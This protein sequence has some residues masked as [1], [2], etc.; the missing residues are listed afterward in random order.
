MGK[1]YG[2]LH[3]KLIC[4]LIIT[5]IFYAGKLKAQCTVCGATTFTVNLTSQVDTAWTQSGPVRNGTCCAG[6][7]CIKFVVFVNPGSDLLSFDVTNPSPSGSA[8]YQINCGGTVSIGTP[9]C[10][11]NQTMVCITYCKPGGDSPIYHITATKTVK[12]S[13]DFTVRA[14]CAATMTVGGLS[15]ASITWTSISPGAVGAYNSYLSCAAACATTTVTPTA[16]TPTLISYLV[17]GSPLTGCPGTNKDTINVYVVPAMTVN[18]TPTNPVVC[19]GG[20]ATTAITATA[21]G[22]SP[23]LTYTWNT[24]ATTQSIGAGVGNY[25]VLVGDATAGCPPISKTITV[26]AVTTPTAPSITSNGPLCA[27]QTLSLNAVSNGATYSW[28]GPNSF[29]SAVQSPTVG[30]VTTAA[31]GVYSAVATTSGCV[32]TTGTLS[33]TINNAPSTPTLG[34]NSPVCSGQNLIFTSN[35]VSSGVYSW[36]GP[37]GFT[38]SVQNPT[39]TGVS[40]L[41]TGT[42]TLFITAA[43]CSSPIGTISVVVNSTPSAPVPNSNAPI[44]AGQNLGFT[45]L[46]GGGTFSWT[47]P[48]GFTSALQNPTITGASS[49]ATGGYSVTTTVAGCTSPAGVINVTVNAIPGIPSP[50]SNSPLCSGQNLN[51]TVVGTATYSWTGPNGFSSTLQNPTITGA[52]TLAT[53][54]YSV[55]ATVAGCTGSAGTVSVTVNQTPAA[56]SPGANTPLC[57]GQNLNLTSTFTAAATYSW[58]GPNGFT[59]TLQNPT[60][61][62]ITLAGA[63]TYSVKG[64]IAGC[65]GPN[66]TIAVVVNTVPAAPAPGSN[67]P[68]CEG[69]NLNLTSTFTAGATYS[70]NGPNGFTS[71][72][73]NPSIAGITVAGSGVYSVNATISGCS[74]PNGTVN[75]VVNPIPAAPVPSANSPICS[76]QTL[77][78]STTFS[79]GA[80]YSWTGPNS[81][82]STLQNPTIV[83]ASTLAAGNYSLSISVAGCASSKGTVAVTVN[84]TPSAPTA[85]GTATLCA[86]SNIN[87]TANPGGFTYN[88]TGPNGFSSTLQN[89]TITGA[90][91]LATGM[92]SVT[93]SAG[94]CTGPFGTFSVNVFGIPSP[95]NLGSNS[96]V[97]TGQNL[98]FTAATIAGASYAW[99][100]PNGFSSALQNPTLTNVTTAAAGNYT[101]SVNVSGCGSAATLIAVT[102]NTTPASPSPGSNAP[103]CVGQNLNLTATFTSGATYAWS[104]PNSFT[105]NVQ[106]PTITGITTAG[107]GVYSVNATMAGC[108]GPTGTLA[109]A[110]NTIPASPTA[111]ANSPLCAGQNLNLTSTFTSGATYSWTGPNGFTSNIQNPT[112]TGI[113][114]AGSGVYSV[115]AT[116]AGCTGPAGTISVTVNPIPATP[117]PLSN[118]PLC[119]GQTISLS[120]SPV[121]GATY[122]WTGPNSFNSTSQ[123]PTIAGASTLAAGNYSL[124][125]TVLGCAS[126]KGTVSV[127]VNQT[128]SAPTAGGTATLCE[129]SNINLTA[130]PAGFSYNWNGPNGFTSTLQNPSITGASTLATGMY[131]VTATSTAGCTGPAGTVSVSVFGN[132][133]PPILSS[134]TPCTGQNLTF[135]ASTILGASYNW[136]GPN[137]FVSTLQN[138]TITAVTLAASGTYTVGVNVSGCG[139]SAATISITVNP[140]PA[141]PVLS[142][143]S[144]ICAGQNINFTISTGGFSYNWTGPNSFTANVQNPSVTGA[145]TLATGIYSATATSGAGCIS[146]VG[147]VSITVNPIPGAPLPLSNSPICAGQNLNFTISPGGASYS[148]TGPNGFT[149]VLQNPTITNA[150]TLA[151][152]DYSVTATQLGCTGPE[153]TISVTVNPIPAAPLLGSNSPICAGQT[154]SLTANGTTTYSWT[155]PN[156]FTS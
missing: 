152:G 3:K 28:T 25:T 37:N 10:V 30:S 108:T 61:T 33:V 155:G 145:S 35:L 51:L 130:N 22:G 97:C 63:G 149:S 136:S 156:S 79:A 121:S 147:T 74:G 88:W 114:T 38:S 21:S 151:T 96:P 8:F 110:V 95:P 11:N 34:S 119:S 144:P 48:N 12:A 36:T 59:S 150:S 112:I 137:G 75:V 46:P 20:S 55:T 153:G 128:P 52:T 124:S 141:T 54:M 29:T 90:T 86:G 41:A 58:A 57:V 76:G 7:N 4:L 89:P 70:W 107:A 148:W 65:T 16:S 113:S 123:N 56:P 142:G 80:T 18:I 117:V 94:G 44:C 82:N 133:P 49:V 43:G 45:A 78:L 9:A 64:T 71:N 125:I 118:S 15:V 91:T 32:G 72:V 131:S 40:T 93:A 120:V 101:L 98:T 1:I 115:N 87:L 140:T 84:Q 69:Q 146:N 129:G 13:D 104:G 23:P 143:N 81:F 47:G 138:P 62:G 126:A 135:T 27:G 5:A 68:L 50:G 42:Y 99:T 102:V 139:S 134:N 31:S 19:S 100:G 60:I 109:V 67:S 2:V 6:S 122:S 106:N 105:S 73:Q 127:T 85:G 116:M 66:G 132:P 14:N 83:G 92:Y 103:I 111:G 77:S 26:A 53:G 24:S 154:I 39:I 17:S